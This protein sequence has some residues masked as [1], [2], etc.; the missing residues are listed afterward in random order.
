MRRSNGFTLIELMIVVAILAII[1][2]IGYPLYTDQ[3]RKARR[4]EAKTALQE[5]M[6]REERFFT[7]NNTYTTNL[8]Q[9]GYGG[10]TFT[11]QEGWYQVSAAACG[12][13][14]IGQCVI[15]SAAPQNDQTNDVC[16][17]FTLNSRG[18]ETDGGGGAD[19]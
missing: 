9:L 14:T 5:A 10:A 3:V 15:L 2:S 4:A 17:T 18:Q 7:T 16:G 12:G 8:G 1:V 11:T 19:C 13:S 6:N